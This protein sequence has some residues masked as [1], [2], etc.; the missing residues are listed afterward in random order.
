MRAIL[1]SQLLHALEGVEGDLELASSWPGTSGVRD[2]LIVREA[3]PGAIGEGELLRLHGDRLCD[4]PLHGKHQAH[5]L[6]VL[7]E[8]V[9]GREEP[10]LDARGTRSLGGGDRSAEIAPYHVIA[11][12][13][14]G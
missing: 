13:V 10:P 4:A 1:A 8:A 3:Q 5:D 6:T 12:G 2:E 14:R 9:N 7:R 11:P